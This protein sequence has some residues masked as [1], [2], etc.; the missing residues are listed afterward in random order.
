MNAID[1]SMCF[2]VMPFGDKVNIDGETVK[3]I[4]QSIEGNAASE[5]NHRAH[6]L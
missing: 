1:D 5:R 2:V 4:R 3:A 6:R